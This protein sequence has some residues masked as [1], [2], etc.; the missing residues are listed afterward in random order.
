MSNKSFPVKAIDAVVNIQTEEALSF[1]PS[2]RRIFYLEKLGIDEGTFTGIRHEE[3]LRRMDEAGIE[4]SFLIAPK[5]GREGLPAA[6]H[7]P[8]QI[9]VDAVE[10]Y[11]DRFY[12]LAGID[13]FEG[14]SG[15]R[16][17]EQAIN[18]FGFI[19]AHVYPHWF[20][21]APD[22]AKYYPFY[23][24]CVELDV[25]IQMQVGQSLI[26]S[27]TSPIR[28]VLQPITIDTVACDFPEL[29]IIGI[30]I[31]I[32]WHE[33][34]IAM[35]WKHPNVYI[36]CDAHAPKHWPESF[37]KYINSY[38]QDKVIF[39][40]DFPVID[41]SRAMDDIAAHGFKPEVLAKLLRYNVER[42]YNLTD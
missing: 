18:E 20:E 34:M 42:I 7:V 30:H 37:I 11:P 28:R 19:G 12:G 26:Y 36:G 39:G 25:P 40:T 3:M 16:A 17:L 15:V 31:G 22:H 10:K 1:R 24:K 9:V 6:Y 29:K 5:I 13:P 33:E 8:Y 32:P 38:G 41:F 2:D 27:P 23:A 21:L 35:A 4:K 14:M